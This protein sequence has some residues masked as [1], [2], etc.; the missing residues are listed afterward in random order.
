MIVLPFFNQ[1]PV[2]I[3]FACIVLALFTFSYSLPLLPFTARKRIREYGWPKILVLASVWTSTTAVLPMI[4]WYKSPVAFP[5]ELLLR[6]VF[7]FSLC[8]LFDIRDVQTD[9]RN[10]IHTLPIKIGLANSYKTINAALLLFVLLS[11]FQYLRFPNTGRLVGAISTGILTYA[12]AQYLKKYPTDRAYMLLADG[13]ML[14]YA[15]IALL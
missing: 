12:V 8:I 6:F 15:F 5:F 7:I 4:F 1:L 9:T 13:V 14:V 2:R 10:N 3:L 11:F